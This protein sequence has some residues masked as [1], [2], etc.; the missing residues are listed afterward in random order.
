[1][2]QKTHPRGLRLGIIQ[3]WDSRWFPNQS[4]DYV[5]WLQEDLKI[6]DFVRERLMRAAVSR[7]AVERW[8]SARCTIHIHTARPGIVI[9]RRGAEVERLAADLEKLLG[10]PVQIK[11]E[12]VRR[13]ELDAR[14]VAEGVAAQIE[15]RTPYRQAMK[16]S[17]QNTMRSGAEGCK[18]MVSGRLGGHE[19]AQ[20][21]YDIQ[22]RV[23]LHTLRADVDYGFC[24][25]RT[26][27]GLIGVKCWIFRGEVISGVVGQDAE[28]LKPRAQGGAAARG[29]TDGRGG[30]DGGGAGRGGR[31]GGGGGGR[32]G[33]GGRGGGGGYRG[34]GGPG[35]GPGGG[36]GYRGPGGP[37]G[38]GRGRPGGG[39]RN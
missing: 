30:R 12:E 3:T 6:A 37:G 8:D 1:M 13:P 28:M 34:P 14:L 39:R 11:I 7:I 15:R 20:S 10:R 35:G 32:G 2:G 17:V 18:V 4:S 31:G 22:G 36:G 33:P 16:R 25:A 27:F 21:Q 9:G 38:G 24:E 19:I 26:N 23:P 29:S 5:E